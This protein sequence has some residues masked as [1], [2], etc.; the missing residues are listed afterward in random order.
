MFNLVFMLFL[1]LNQ[2]GSI[3][4]YVLNN[5]KPAT[6]EECT[7]AIPNLTEA[8]KQSHPGSDVHVWCVPLDWPFPP[9]D[10]MKGSI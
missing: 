5:D 1:F 3:D 10:P 6:V 8:V 7:A 4:S 9:K 2:D